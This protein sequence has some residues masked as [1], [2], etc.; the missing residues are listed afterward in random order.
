MN[1][2]NLTKRFDKAKAEFLEA[3]IEYQGETIDFLVKS[4]SYAADDEYIWLKRADGQ[5]TSEGLQRRIHRLVR[6]QAE[7]GLE[8]I[9]LED[10]VTYPLDL[11]MVIN[12]KI[13]EVQG[14]DTEIDGAIDDAK[15]KP[16]KKK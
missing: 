6:V 1:L 5:S 11:L 14:I 4:R 12:E 16:E 13:S 15:K 2:K 10:V 9:A 3:S 8:E 7:D